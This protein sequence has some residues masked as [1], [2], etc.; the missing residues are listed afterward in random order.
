MRRLPEHRYISIAIAIQKKISFESDNPL[1]LCLY[2][3]LLN[4]KTDL[5]YVED[6]YE[7]FIHQND[8]HILNALIIAKATKEYIASTLSMNLHLI[9]AYQ[10]LFFDKTVFRHDFDIKNYI[11]T[12]QLN[13]DLKNYYLVSCEKGFKALANTFK[14]GE[15]D[16]V[17]PKEVLN[18][19]L[20]DQ[21]DRAKAHRGLSITSAIAKEAYKWSQLAA[22]T[23]NTMLKDKQ[24]NNINSITELMLSLKTIDHTTSVESAKIDPSTIYH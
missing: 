22:N 6:A 8:R 23:A 2:T 4:N 17:D 11:N 21:L 5:E 9:E 13:T 3:L 18:E 15:R 16:A 14:I 24:S 7:I 12:L 10:Y 1:E 20:N 19:L